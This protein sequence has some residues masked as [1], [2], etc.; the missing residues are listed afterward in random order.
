[1]TTWR[2]R[3]APGAPGLPAFLPGAAS[4]PL[5]F[6]AAAASP[7]GQ[8]P[9]QLPLLPTERPQG[10]DRAVLHL[11][12]LARLTDRNSSGRAEASRPAGELS[13][14]GAP[15]PV[16]APQCPRPRGQALSGRGPVPVGAP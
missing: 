14:G 7:L 11:Q 5:S 2:P 16:G 13:Q 15:V 10:F 12:P 8:S 9:L 1:M 4:P 3:P 6:A